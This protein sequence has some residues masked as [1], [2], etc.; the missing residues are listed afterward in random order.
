MMITSTTPGM[1][2]EALSNEAHAILKASHQ[3]PLT[4]IA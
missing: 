2:L 1:P 4:L 3:Q